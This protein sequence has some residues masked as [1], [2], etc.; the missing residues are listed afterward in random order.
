MSIQNP[1]RCIMETVELGGDTDT[2]GAMAGALAGALHGT[3][4]LP[5]RWYDNIENENDFRRDQIIA[6]ASRLAELDLR[7]VE[8]ADV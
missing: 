6:V 2:L 1:E 8:H 3:S 5:L 7:S 4:W